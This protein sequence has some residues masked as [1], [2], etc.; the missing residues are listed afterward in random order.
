MLS[1]AAGVVERA[2][3]EGLPIVM[4][5]DGLSLAAEGPGGV[6]GRAAREGGGAR[7]AL[8]RVVRPHTPP[9]FPHR[10]LSVLRIGAERALLPRAYP[11]SSGKHTHTRSSQVLTPNP[12]E[13][14][15][16]CTAW[17]LDDAAAQAAA[18]EGEAAREAIKLL[19]GKIGARAPRRTAHSRC[20]LAPGSPPAGP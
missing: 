15:R 17:G 6:L 19:A 5:G 3:R 8:G 20:S 7:E 11:L 16:L 10:S 18:G 14:R 2:L 4:D 12:N 9:P 1:D 13:L